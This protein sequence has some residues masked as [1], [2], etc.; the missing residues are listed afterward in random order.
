M[1]DAADNLGRGADDRRD[2]YIA[3]GEQKRSH[4]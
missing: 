2:S 1:V 3:Q 4:I